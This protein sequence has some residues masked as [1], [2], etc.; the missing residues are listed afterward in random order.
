[1]SGMRKSDPA[2]ASGN[3]ATSEPTDPPEISSATNP[4]QTERG[5]VDTPGIT[6]AL[7]AE[8]HPEDAGNASSNAFSDA[9]RGE[10]DELRRDR[11]DRLSRSEEERKLPGRLVLANGKTVAVENTNSTAHFDDE[12]GVNVPVVSSFMVPTDSD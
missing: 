6:P 3:R 11:A 4:Q 8:T 1:M 7:L 5:T 12:L 9:E 2:D 10:L